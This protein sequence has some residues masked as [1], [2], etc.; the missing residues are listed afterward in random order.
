MHIKVIFL[1]ITLEETTLIM[2]SD[3]HV[4]TVYNR[5]LYTPHNAQKEMERKQL[6]MPSGR[7]GSF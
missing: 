7:N 1:Y 2:A 3:N 5:S 6:F 4:E